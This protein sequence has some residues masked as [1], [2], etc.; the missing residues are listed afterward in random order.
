MA[1]KLAAARAISNAK[2]LKQ[3]AY[4]YPHSKHFTIPS[5]DNFENNV[6]TL[7]IVFTHLF[8]Y[9]EQLQ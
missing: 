2:Q 1:S 3:K 4:F 7:F 8:H 9:Y 6:S 5:Y